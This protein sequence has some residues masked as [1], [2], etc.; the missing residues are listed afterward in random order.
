MEA[1]ELVRAVGGKTDGVPFVRDL[2]AGVQHLAAQ[3]IGGPA[4][5]AVH[6]PPQDMAHLPEG[7]RGAQDDGRVVVVQE[8]Q[9]GD[10]GAVTLAQPVPGLDGHAAVGRQGGQHFFLLAPKLDSKYVVGKWQGH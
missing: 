3:D 5:E 2:P 6:L 7:W 10:G 4:V 8:P 9:H 1:L